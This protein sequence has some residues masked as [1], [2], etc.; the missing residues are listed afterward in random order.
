MLCGRWGASPR[1]HQTDRLT[2]AVN[3]PDNPEAIHADVSR[4]V[5]IITGS[6]DGASIAGVRMR[7]A[8]SSS[9]TTALSDAVDQ[10]LMLRGS[11]DFASR[12]AYEEFLTKPVFPAQQWPHRAL[13]ARSE[14]GH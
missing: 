8:M 14:S 5:S 11:R 6:S 3:K 10:A 9:A 1:Q 12:A 2:A 4:I 7:T 13:Q